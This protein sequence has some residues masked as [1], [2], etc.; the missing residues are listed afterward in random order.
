MNRARD[1]VLAGAALAG[2]QHG[3]VVPLQALDLLDDAVHGGAGAD[4][5]GQQR[6]ER[7]LV[8]LL[9]RP[10][11]GRSRAPHSSKPWRATAANMRSRRGSRLGSRRAAT[12]AQARGP[13]WSRPSGSV[14]SRAV[15][16]LAASLRRGARQ[17]AGDVGV[18]P[19][20]GDDAHVAT[21]PGDEDD[22]GV[23]LDGFEQRGRGLARQQ[24]RQDRRVHETPHDRFV[25][26][27]GRDRPAGVAA[28]ASSSALTAAT[29][30]QIAL[31][32]ERSRRSNRP[33]RDSV[34]P[35]SRVPPRAARRPSARWLSAA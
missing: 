1:E 24:L 13:S 25:G 30:R 11:R 12:M 3:Q 20:S 21:R 33:D 34:R 28:P 14:S 17:R 18:A 29:S 19:G 31:G 26:V 5:P 22:G 27:D 23:G 8:D 9:G 15:A 16:V 4:E 32:A 6:L 2:D 7:T 35:P 10:A